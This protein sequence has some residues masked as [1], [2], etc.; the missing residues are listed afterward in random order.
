MVRS[1]YWENKVTFKVTL[2]IK[3]SPAAACMVTLRQKSLMQNNNCGQFEFM[4]IFTAENK[5]QNIQ[6]S[7]CCK[8]PF[9]PAST[10][11]QLLTLESENGLKTVRFILEVMST[12]DV[13]LSS[14]KPSMLY[15]TLFY[16]FS[17]YLE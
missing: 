8:L 1:S 2:N 6:K 5:Y 3:H 9:E 11:C 7:S 10:E 4:M 13:K 12:N 15:K 16:Y 14:K 17:S